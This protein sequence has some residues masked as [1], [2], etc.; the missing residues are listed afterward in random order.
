MV[1]KKRRL[2]SKRNFLLIFIIFSILALTLNIS[3]LGLTPAKKEINFNP[4]LETTFN[5]KS[6]ADENQEVYVYAEGD[7]AKYVSF[8]KNTLNGS[9]PFNVT[10]KFPESI[11]TPGRHR[12]FIVAEEKIDE[13]L[14]A[15]IGTRIIVKGV[16]YIDIPYPGKYLEILSFSSGDANVGEPVKF[17][18]SL[19]NRGTEDLTVEPVINIFSDDKKIE[20]LSF[21]ERIIKSQ[22]TLD[23]KKMLDTADYKAGKYTASL[24]VDY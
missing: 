24:V 22:E 7:L 19:A 16:I 13:E 6:L 23:L 10:I 18:L 17:E 20:S 2:Y 9:E 21:K 8:S 12:I 11:E 15:T 3:S 4:N 5:Y 1:F 14:A